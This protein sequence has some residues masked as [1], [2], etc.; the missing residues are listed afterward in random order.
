[1]CIT[2]LMIYVCDRDSMS[3]Y[4]SEHSRRMTVLWTK[5]FV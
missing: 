2:F 1:M 5:I 3:V 4:A